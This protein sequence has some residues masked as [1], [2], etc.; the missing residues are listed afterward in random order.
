M[1]NRLAL[2]IYLVR[3]T[4]GKDS[5]SFCKCFII[6]LEIAMPKTSSI[7]DNNTLYPDSF[8]FCVSGGGGDQETSISVELG[9]SVVMLIGGAVGA[10]KNQSGFS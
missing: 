2:F 7:Y 8:P 1:K 5:L 3:V 6:L 10:V 9:A 4:C